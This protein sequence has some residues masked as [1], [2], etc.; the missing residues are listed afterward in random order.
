[1][2]NEFEEEANAFRVR[3][4]SH[5]PAN[6]SD[7]SLPVLKGHLLAE[8][9]LTHYVSCKVSHPKHLR[10]TDNHWGFANKV[11][12]AS[13]LASNEHHD[14]WVWSALKKLNALRNRLSHSLESKGLDKLISDF[15][16]SVKPHTP[17]RYQGEK[18]TVYGCV[19]FAVTG[20]LIVIKAEEGKIE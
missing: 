9:L 16:N 8:E 7:I 13:S 5:I 4:M 20:L 18:I 12:L 2:R 1:M 14:V 19:L 10:L 11:E 6:S 3:F 17:K 15:C